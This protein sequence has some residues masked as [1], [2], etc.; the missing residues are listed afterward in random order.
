MLRALF[1]L[2]LSLGSHA[3]EVNL[4]YNGIS[5]NDLILNGQL[6]MA[7]ASSSRY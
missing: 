1:L 6:P 3:A 2:F 4:P 5:H 7:N